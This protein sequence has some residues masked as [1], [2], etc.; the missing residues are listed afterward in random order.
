MGVFY[1]D[2]DTHRRTRSENFQHLAQEILRE[3]DRLGSIGKTIEANSVIYQGNLDVIM[4]R[5]LNRL[6]AIR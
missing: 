6:K 3:L 4:D 2:P 5:T 1:D